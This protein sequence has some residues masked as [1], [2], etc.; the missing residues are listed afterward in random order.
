MPPRVCTGSFRVQS[1]TL[2]ELSAALKQMD[3]SKSSDVDT[4]T[5]NVLKLAFPV[6]EPHLLHIVSNSLVSGKAAII[7]PLFKGGTQ[8]GRNNFRPI[9]ILSTVGK[10]G[11][12]VV[13]NQLVC[14]L[15]EHHC[16]MS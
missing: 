13:A 11:E 9:S 15:S 6:V 10:L 3:A 5:V 8:D 14:Y 4:L 2:P 1:L 7:T 12:R 16:D